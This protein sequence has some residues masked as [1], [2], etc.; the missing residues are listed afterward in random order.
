MSSPPAEAPPLARKPGGKPKFNKLKLIKRT[1]SGG[2][3]SQGGPLEG[4][5]AGEPALDVLNFFDRSKESYVPQR[6]S[7]KRSPDPGGSE[8][9]SPKKECVE[10][11]YSSSSDGESQ[12]RRLARQNRR[13]PL[14]H[15]RFVCHVSPEGMNAHR[16]RVQT[17]GPVWLAGWEGQS[18]NH[19]L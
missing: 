4:L 14:V 13:A 6:K 2:G 3:A 5:P 17:L 19:H 16:L 10:G 7:R 1:S 18:C 9:P 12:G 8:V 11:N 15:E